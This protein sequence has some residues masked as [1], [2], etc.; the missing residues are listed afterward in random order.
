MVFGIVVIVLAINGHNTVTTELKQQNITGTP[1]MT[2]SA[3]KAEGEKAGLKNV[4]YPTCTVAGQSVDTG[5]EAR[6]FAQYMNIHALEATGGYTYSEMG[7]YA[8]KPDTPKSQLEAGGGTSNAQ[9]AQTDPT[10]GQPV[11][12][13]ARNVWVTET[14]LSTALNTSYMATQLSL[15]SLVVGIALILAGI[16]F[17]VLALGATAPTKEGTVAV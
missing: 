9:Y 1:D 3:I 11:Q 8:A 7:I 12:N 5:T 15:F 16:G 10:T 14:A 13:A 2:P 6:C 17:V 4:S